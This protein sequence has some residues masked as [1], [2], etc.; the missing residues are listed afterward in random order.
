MRKYDNYSKVS[1]YTVIGSW[2]KT[3]I[4]GV[5]AVGRAALQHHRIPLLTKF[6]INILVDP[7]TRLTHYR[8]GR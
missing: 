7:T 8:H 3:C 6:P 2:E 4:C 5:P 1:S